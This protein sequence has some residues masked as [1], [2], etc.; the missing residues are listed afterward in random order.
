MGPLT[1]Q[2][3]PLPLPQSPECS[4]SPHSGFLASK[5]L[6]LLPNLPSAHLLLGDQVSHITKNH[7]AVGNTEG[8]SGSKM[9]VESS[10][11]RKGDG[12]SGSEH[13]DTGME[14]LILGMGESDHEY[15]EGLGWG[16]GLHHPLALLT[17][18]P[19]QAIKS[20]DHPAQRDSI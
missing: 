15:W 19:W 4:I 12:V 8:H 7:P 20:P 10:P 2:C 13:S 5:P 3:R 6:T 9:R 14:A 1:L 17:R 11:P 18:Q 16:E